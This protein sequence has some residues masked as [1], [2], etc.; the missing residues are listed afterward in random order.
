MKLR[1]RKTRRIICRAYYAKNNIAMGRWR[2]SSPM[3]GGWVM[4]G[5]AQRLH[6]N[7]IKVNDLSEHQRRAIATQF[8]L[9]MKFS[10]TK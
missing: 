8:K 4:R 6:F 9:Q 10:A 3:G 2:R 7:R 1:H 5:R